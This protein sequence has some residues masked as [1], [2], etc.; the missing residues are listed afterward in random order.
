M[1]FNCLVIMTP[2]KTDTRYLGTWWYRRPAFFRAVARP[3]DFTFPATHTASHIAGLQPH[4][5][6]GTDGQCRTGS[7]LQYES[8]TRALSNCL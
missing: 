8:E 6:A 4:T 7:L 2:K 5:A 1:F 3:T